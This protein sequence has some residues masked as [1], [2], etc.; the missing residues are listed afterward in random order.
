MGA[1]QAKRSI[2]IPGSVGVPRA[3]GSSQVGIDAAPVTFICRSQASFE[4]KALVDLVTHRDL[5][6]CAKAAIRLIVCQDVET[7]ID[8]IA[9]ATAPP[10]KPVRATSVIT[11]RR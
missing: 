11:W 5:R 3:D 2:V 10:H 7:D 8:A 1:R 9:Q 4:A 6:G